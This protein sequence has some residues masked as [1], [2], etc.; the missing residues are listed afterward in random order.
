MEMP[1]AVHILVI[2]VA[3]AFMCF[4]LYKAMYDLFSWHRRDLVRQLKEK[5]FTEITGSRMPAARVS[6]YFPE[7]PANG[8]NY[9]RV[10]LFHVHIYKVEYTQ[11]NG[12][13]CKAFARVEA[14]YLG[15]TDVLIKKVG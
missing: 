5:G 12:A 2:L 8:L 3:F 7:R 4:M 11:P 6:D 1:L 13:R 15:R 10:P 9:G 14:R